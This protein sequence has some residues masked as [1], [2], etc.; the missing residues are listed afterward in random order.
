MFDN[1]TD[2]QMLEKMYS[3]VYCTVFIFRNESST[4]FDNTTDM[5]MLEKVNSIVDFI[6]EDSPNN[7]CHFHQKKGNNSCFNGRLYGI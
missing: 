1:T 7:I 2:M 6:L 3:A 4:V 5:Q